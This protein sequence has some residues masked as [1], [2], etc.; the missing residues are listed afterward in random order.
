MK[1]LRLFSRLFIGIIFVFSGLVKALDPLGSK[2]KF[3]DYFDA[4]GLEFLADYALPFAI[5]MSAAEFIIGIAFIFGVWNR[6]NSWIALFFM[7]FFTPLTLW[8][9]IANPVADCGC[10]GDAII[11][12]NWQTFFKNLIIDV[13]IVIIFLQRNKFRKYNKAWIEWIIVIVFSLFI[14][15]LSIHAIRH[16]P[17]IDF[18]AWKVGSQMAMEEMEPPQA[19]V[20]YKNIETGEEEEYPSDNYPWDDST[21]MATHEFVTSRVDEI[22]YADKILRMED[23]YGEDVTNSLISKEK[24]YQ[25][26]VVSYYLDDAC[27]TG[28]DRLVEFYNQIEGTDTE[29]FIV[30]GSLPDEIDAFYEHHDVFIDAYLADEIALKT[31]IRANPGVLLLN[32]GVI[33]EKWNIHDLPDYNEI[34]F[35]ELSEKNL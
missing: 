32:Q 13:F 2:Y 22:P 7:A 3:I 24:S 27:E 6:L 4:M 1:A 30:T 25:F 17:I 19:Y 28:L 26:M 20:I 9:A 34:D 35:D 11:L 31:V 18:R 10:F 12:T 21:W 29:F 8:L 14:F 23:T 5:L 16:L 15:G 33:I